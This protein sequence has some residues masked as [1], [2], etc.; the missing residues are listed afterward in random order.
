MAAHLEGGGDEIKRPAMEREANMQQF[1]EAVDQ[2]RTWD[3]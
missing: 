2:I 1:Q 3:V